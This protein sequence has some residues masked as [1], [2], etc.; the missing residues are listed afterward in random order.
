VPQD[1]EELYAIRVANDPYLARF[2]PAREPGWLSVEG[3]HAMIA[4]PGPERFAIVDDGAIVGTI[5][6]SN[7]VRGFLQS[8][9]VGYWVARDRQGR[10]LATR[11]VAEVLR[12]AFDELG[13]HRV[14]AGT[15][16]DNIASQRVLEKNSFTRIGVAR[17]Y[18]H[19][20]GD[21]RDHILFERLADD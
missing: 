5:A 21:W 10:G 4:A 11:A 3:Q 12:V 17:R 15:L 2:E 9:N 18:L 14:E 19:I 6:L 13:L 16:V 8:A 1:A 7:I 20:A